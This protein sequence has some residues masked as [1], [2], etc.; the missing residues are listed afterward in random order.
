MQAQPNEILG[1]K[2]ANNIMKIEYCGG[3]GYRR[4]AVEIINK[5][6]ELFGAGQFAYH[7]YMDP[8]VTGRLEV[9]VF[10]GSKAETG[11]GVL[12]HSKKASGK[13]VSAD[14]NGFFANLEQAVA[15]WG[16]LLIYER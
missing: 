7:L 13:Y 5:V 14:W 15:K 6:E 11:S 8:G 3:W 2:D 12:I 4:L 10:P 16:T 1:N 9:T